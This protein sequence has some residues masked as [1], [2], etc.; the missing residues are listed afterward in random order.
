MHAGNRDSVVRRYA[1]DTAD[2]NVPGL[3]SL[4]TFGGPAVEE[5]LIAFMLTDQ[6]R[7]FLTID[8]S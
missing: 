6:C 4:L 7:F 8:S 1:V 5:Q 2:R 3:Y